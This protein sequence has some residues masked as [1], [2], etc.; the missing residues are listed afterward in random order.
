MSPEQARG[1]GGPAQ[2]LWSFGCV[3]YECLAG[4]PAFEGE[5]V[6]DLIARILE[7]EPDWSALPAGTP[8]RVCE[9][10]KRCLRKNTAERPRDIRD[11]RLEVVE[12]AGGGVT[13]GRAALPSV[14]VLPFINR[15]P[16]PKTTTSPTASPRT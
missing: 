6:S 5:T 2:R 7:R 9:I 3:L 14:A 11:V 12:E 15:A 8:S 10:L 1:R 16:I 4:R 13:S